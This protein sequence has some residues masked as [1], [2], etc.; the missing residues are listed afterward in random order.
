MQA[1]RKDTIGGD[2]LPEIVAANQALWGGTARKFVRIDI[3]R[4]QLP[5]AD[6]V[7]C[8]DCFVHLSNA[9]VLEAVRNITNGSIEYLL[10][11]TFPECDENVDIVTGDWRVINL[12]LPPFNF[13]APELI[14]NEECTESDGMFADK[15]LALWKVGNMRRT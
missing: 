4:D 2:I 3:I 8:R 7:L 9:E 12:Q 5:A 1:C 15:S 14:I 11:T 10:T 6:L 13:P